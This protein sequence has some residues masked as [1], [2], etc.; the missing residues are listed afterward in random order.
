[1]LEN[2]PRP[3]TVDECIGSVSHGTMVTEHLLEAFIPH[4]R[5]RGMDKTTHDAEVALR[6]L[7]LAEAS[8]STIATMEAIDH[9]S[10][11]LNEDVWDAMNEIAPDELYF[12]ANPG[13]GSDY[14]FWPVEWIEH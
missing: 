9:A 14:G 2:N 4:L 10:Y 7:K 3:Y 13:D 12:G 8:D 11:I 1:M 6:Y 5:D